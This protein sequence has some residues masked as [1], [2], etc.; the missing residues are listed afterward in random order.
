MSLS[1]SA[2]VQS[3]TTP[4]T[5]IWPLGALALVIGLQAL[6]LLAPLERRLLDFKFEL[7]QRPAGKQLVLVEIDPPS[8][9]RLGAWPWPR[10]RHGRAI[11]ALTDAGARAIA[12]DIDVSEPADPADDRRF[13]LALARADGRV[14]LPLFRA[15]VEAGEGYRWDYSQPLR[16]FARLAETATVNVWP[17]S[18][19]L[20]RRLPQWDRWPGGSV[21]S[22]SAALAGPVARRAAPDGGRIDYGVDYGIDPDTIP[23]LSYADVLE[24]RF[25]PGLVAGRDV[26]IGAGAGVLRDGLP[27]PLHGTVSGIQLHALGVHSLLAGRALEPPPPAVGLAIAL[28]ITLA[29]GHGFRRLG[30]R[31]ALAATL[32]G[33]AGLVL[34]SCG[35]Q[36]AVPVTLE[37]VPHGLLLLL[38]FAGA[39]VGRFDRRELGLLI[40]SLRLRPL[41]AFMRSVVETSFDGILTVDQDGRVR[42]ANRSAT[43]I[44]EIDGEALVGRPVTELVP[45]F[46]EP[47]QA[48]VERRDPVLGQREI[49]GLRQGIERF[50]LEIGVTELR[51]AG[52]RYF[53]A[54]LR[55]VTERRQQQA[56]L[57]HQAM[58]DSLTGLP[59]RHHLADRLAQ[60]IAQA[61]LQ[62]RPMA[63]L[64]VDLDRFKAVNDTLGH[65]IGDRLLCQVAERLVGPLQACDSIARLGGDE[66]AVVL[67]CVGAEASGQTVADRLLEALAEPFSIEG[68]SLE[69]GASIGISLFPEHAADGPRLLQ[70]ADVAMYQAKQAGGGTA[71]YDEHRDHNSVRHLTIT[72]ELR[73]AIEDDQ[74]SFYYQPKIDLSSGRVVG[75]EALIRWRHPELG[76][77]PPDEFIVLAEQTGL[78]G[79]LTAWTFER[80][81][82][83]VADWRAL[84][85][86]LAVSVNLSARTLHDEALPDMVAGA[87][88]RWSV[89]PSLV[90]VEIT[91]TAIMLDPERAARVVGRLH[92][93]GLHLSVDDF[94]TGHSSLAYLKRLPLDELKIDRTF[95]MQMTDNDDDAVIVRSTIDL[96]H[97]L[98]L[99]V[100]AEGVE[101]EQHLRLLSGLACDTAQGYF[102]SRPVPPEAF[103]A[104]CRARG[105]LPPAVASRPAASAQSLLVSA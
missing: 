89:P 16:R 100:V 46:F 32:A 72:G 1:G 48:S 2:T 18:D 9:D 75:A 25:D 101:S 69:I 37:I 63:L 6:G 7:L 92:D 26:L 81:L 97:S 40:R 95:V 27:V 43:R 99:E 21:T 98:G 44:F 54:I 10:A 60:A 76:F 57:E 67:P 23:R 22:I 86:E 71:V 105:E 78:I 91:E 74:L 11:E 36:A 103:E 15:A 58:H 24:G 5:W 8:L 3:A 45:D 94:G 31:S 56:L 61:R 4:T 66:F 59:N 17:A 50:A 33:L 14:L 42:T 84:G 62:E 41:D 70:C 20:I 19:G 53:V 93:L 12:L 28:A 88:E 77:V 82:A 68:L 55:D 13:E 39:L 38:L 79:A 90:T 65:Q 29:A 87:L 34:L 35:L 64:L 52:Q 96:A 47:A 102:I 83:Q 73:R 85:L 49:S 51:S 80:A 30:W 104:W